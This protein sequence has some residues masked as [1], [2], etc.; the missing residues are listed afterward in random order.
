MTDLKFGL[1]TCRYCD[2]FEKSKKNLQGAINQ[3]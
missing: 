1:D 3:K 2:Y